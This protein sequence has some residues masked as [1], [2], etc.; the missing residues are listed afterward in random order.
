MTPLNRLAVFFFTWAG[1]T[2]GV[3]AISMLAERFACLAWV[4]SVMLAILSG[5][6]AHIL[7][8]PKEPK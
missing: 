3:A 7:V 4:A 5:I 2:F 6:F 8:Y 1:I